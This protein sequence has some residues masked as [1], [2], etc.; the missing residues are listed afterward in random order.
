MCTISH[1]SDSIEQCAMKLLSCM[2]TIRISGSLDRISMGCSVMFSSLNHTCF[3]G[4]HGRVAGCLSMRHLSCWDILTFWPQ[5]S[6]ARDCQRNALSCFATLHSTVSSLPRWSTPTLSQ[7][8]L[9]TW[10]DKHSSSQPGL[11]AAL[12][13]RSHEAT[14]C[15]PISSTL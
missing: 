8:R 11:V 15:K 9:L 2:N 5:L 6:L 4:K 7:T 13:T 1:T 10:R 14:F 3:A 12:G